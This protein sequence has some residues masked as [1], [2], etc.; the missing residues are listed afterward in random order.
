MWHNF[1]LL[2]V[3]SL[4]VRVL[5]MSAGGLPEPIA[6]ARRNEKRN[7]ARHK[8]ERSKHDPRG[9]DPA[10][11]TEEAFARARKLMPPSWWKCLIELLA[12]R[13]E[14][15]HAGLYHRRWEI[16]TSFHEMKVTQKMESSQCSR[17]P[18]SIRYEVAG[19]VVLYLLIHRLM[20]EA[21]QAAEK[22]G[23]P[24]GLSFKHALEELATVWNVL[25]NKRAGFWCA[26]ESRIEGA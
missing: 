7:A 6:R 1:S 10:S 25:L 18:E 22:E 21:A 12:E 13:F 2:S 11:L 23:D 9:K 15:D 5:N 19:H 8:T 3:L 17:T 4:T 26:Y 16:E 20:A 14:K 24:L